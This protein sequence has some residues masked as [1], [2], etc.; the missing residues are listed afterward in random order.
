MGKQVMPTKK[1]GRPPKPPGSH[2][3]N[4]QIQFGRRC[5]ADVD[6]VDAAAKAAGMGRAEWAW[7]VLLKAA[8]RSRI[9]T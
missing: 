5:Q 9:G 8:K 2:Q 7:M 4:P 3:I 6:A 1:L